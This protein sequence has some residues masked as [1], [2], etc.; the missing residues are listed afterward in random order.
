MILNYRN[1]N[2]LNALF[3]GT[4]RQLISR[5]ELSAILDFPTP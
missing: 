2:E 4:L 3:I 1:Y 5:A